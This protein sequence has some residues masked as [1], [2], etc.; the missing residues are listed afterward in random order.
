M[1]AFAINQKCARRR[2]ISANYYHIPETR[3][4]ADRCLNKEP[5]HYRT[6]LTLLASSVPPGISRPSSPSPDRGRDKTRQSRT[7]IGE[8]CRELLRYLP[9]LFLPYKENN[10]ALKS[11][12]PL[13]HKNTSSPLGLGSWQ[14]PPVD[15]LLTLLHGF[16][17]A[18]RVPLTPCHRDSKKNPSWG[19][20]DT[21]YA[22]ESPLPGGSGRGSA[23]K[24]SCRLIKRG[25][26]MLEIKCGPLL[27]VYE[28]S[29]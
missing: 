22:F 9:L 18:W 13:L 11:V 4:F 26:Q 5:G 12:F 14:A 21:R 23:I 29:I 25:L 3:E 24:E 8:V 27:R 20:F 16:G 7:G 10:F 1:R 6:A 2:K 28:A 15:I 17:W 19:Y